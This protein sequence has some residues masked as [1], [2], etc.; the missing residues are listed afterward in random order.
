MLRMARVDASSPRMSSSLFIIIFFALAI[1][2][3]LAYKLC[4]LKLDH[5]AAPIFISTYILLGVAL[6]MPW[7][8][9]LFVEGIEQLISMPLILSL[10]LL[11]GV[12]FW[13]ASYGGQQL[14]HN[15][16]SYARYTLPPALAIAAIINVFFGEIL[17]LVEWVAV[18]GL[19][20]SGIAFFLKGHIQDL[21][22]P[23]KILFVK[24]VGALVCLIVLDHI[25]I[26]HS[27]WYVLLFTS[28]VAVFVVCLLYRKPLAVWKSAIFS[29]LGMLGGLLMVTYEF[30][31]FYP[32]VTLVPVTV[33]STVQAAAT[34]IVL[35]LTAMIWGERTWK[36][37]LIWG[38]LAI[39]FIL[40]LIFVD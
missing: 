28:N 2:K 30:V 33:M 8:H 39:G 16:L 35:V 40:P 34:P 7:F 22:H 19:A 29:K 27:N 6:T 25:T 11:K 9:D 15:S 21:D 14:T 38:V 10:C 36:E 3:P 17:T 1:A 12:I 23:T 13:Y 32:M 31:K 37:Q 24:L 20:L 18:I 26:S 5:R 4:A